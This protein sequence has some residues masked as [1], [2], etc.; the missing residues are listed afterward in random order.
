MSNLPLYEI[1]LRFP[2]EVR[3]V[4][5]TFIV[6]KRIL[7]VNGSILRK[8]KVAVPVTE[9]KK[10]EVNIDIKFENPMLDDLL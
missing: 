3:K 5:A 7:N 2:F 4:S 6:E 1:S 8:K 9:E 10:K